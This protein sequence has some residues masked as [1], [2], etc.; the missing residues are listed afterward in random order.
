MSAVTTFYSNLMGLSAANLKSQSFIARNPTFDTGIAGN[1]SWTAIVDTE[2]AMTVFN[3]TSK[4]V[5]PD[6]LL[7]RT[8]AAG[9]NN[10]ENSFIFRLDNINGYASGG[11]TLTNASTYMSGSDTT[12]R[13]SDVVCN[14][15][16]LT[17]VAS[18][19]LAEDVGRIEWKHAAA[20]ALEV[21]DML[22]VEFG[23]IG[24]GQPHAETFEAIYTTGCPM[25]WIGPGATLKIYMFQTAGSAASSFEV[26]L[27][28]LEVDE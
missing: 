22:H 6:T 19:S 24:A 18:S 25:I 2:V 26:Q 28:W 12:N 15:G 27:S 1:A 4:I 21:N 10:T 3:G 20:P 17:G 7:L 11:T 14:F 8:T 13:T 5:V 16:D 23:G 9:T